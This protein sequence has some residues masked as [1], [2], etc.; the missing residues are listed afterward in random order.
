MMI[1]F[2]NVEY[3]KELIASIFVAGTLI[4][5]F[6]LHSEKRHVILDMSFLRF[7]FLFEFTPLVSISFKPV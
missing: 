4:K 2:Q 1:R 3:T 6:K 7:C 5:A